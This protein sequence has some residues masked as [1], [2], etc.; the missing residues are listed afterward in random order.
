MM[1]V[2][3]LCITFSKR[4][5]RDSVRGRIWTKFVPPEVAV[6]SARRKLEEDLYR[7]FFIG[8]GVLLIIVSVWIV[9]R[10]YLGSD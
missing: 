5:A 1:L 4:L 8:G 7:W 10:V 3:V 2:G 6:V 9:A